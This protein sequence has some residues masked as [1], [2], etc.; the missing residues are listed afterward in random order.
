MVGINLLLE[1]ILTGKRP[2]TVHTD[3]AAFRTSR[4]L[5]IPAKQKA[6]SYADL[7]AFIE[8]RRRALPG[9]G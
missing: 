1:A 2:E 9:V 6:R 7:W 4:G 3:L 5:A 8:E